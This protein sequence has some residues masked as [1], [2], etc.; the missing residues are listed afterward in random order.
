MRNY[1]K[2]KVLPSRSLCRYSAKQSRRRLKQRYVP[3]LLLV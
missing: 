1:K 3:S 2:K